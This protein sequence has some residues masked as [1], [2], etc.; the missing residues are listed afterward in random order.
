M[1][2]NVRLRLTR[3]ELVLFGFAIGLLAVGIV[4][5]NLIVIYGG[6]EIGILACLLGFSI[7]PSTVSEGIVRVLVTI[8]NYSALFTWLVSWGL[9]TTAMLNM[10]GTTV[11]DAIA[12]ALIGFIPWVSVTVGESCA[13]VLGMDSEL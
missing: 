3:A 2:R 5:D 4:L 7:I 10:A 12:V 9:F 11:E 1:N 13:I 8:T 6:A